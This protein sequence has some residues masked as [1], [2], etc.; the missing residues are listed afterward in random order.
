MDDIHD[1]ERAERKGRRFPA[2]VL[3]TLVAIISASWLGMFSFLGTNSAF[4]T[5]EDLGDRYFCNADDMELEFPDLSQLSEVWTADGVLLGK[6]TERNSQPTP[7]EDIPE[8]V[9][10]A[11]LSAEDAHFYEHEGVDFRSLARAI[12]DN[13]RGGSTQGGSTITQQIVKQQFLTTDRTVERKICEAVVAAE[14]ER[15]YSKDQILEFYANS[16]FYGENAYGVTAAAQEYFGKTLE[17]LSPEEAAAMVTPI[18]N[19]TFYDLRDKPVNVVRARDAV[20][21]QMVENGYLTPA[22]G[23]AATSRPLRTVPH[24][25]FEELAP[26]VIISARDQVLNDPRY[27]LGDTYLQRK[28]AL[29]GCPA[30]DTECAGGGGLKIVVTVDYSLQQVANRILRAWFAPGVEGPTGA[31]AMVDNRDGAVKVMASGLDFGDDV[32]AGERPYDLASRGRRQAGSSF[33]PFTLIAALESGATDG[34]AITL[35]SFWDASS[36]VKIE[37]GYPCS[38]DGDIWTVSNAGGGGSGRR[39]A[40]GSSRAGACP[41]SDPGAPG[42]AALSTGPRSRSRTS[43]A[44][45]RPHPHPTDRR[46]HAVGSRGS[47]S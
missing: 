4:G 29:F 17:E 19:P 43:R 23:E 8:L 44:D 28:R 31:I 5:F 12:I 22:A 30:E 20:L 38:P 35:G 21:A 6:L 46:G 18:R 27:G 45:A 10:G 9:I 3:L 33:K 15:R 37:C 24:G 40:A 11:L 16:T 14:L 2:A 47:R 26:Q 41:C 36:P 25:E 39:A 34:W 7:L 42:T 1:Q 32:D 13:A